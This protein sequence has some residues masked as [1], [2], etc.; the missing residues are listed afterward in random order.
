M[1]RGLESKYAFSFF[2]AAW[3]FIRSW[4]WQN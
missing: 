2:A 1:I 3:V 4:Y